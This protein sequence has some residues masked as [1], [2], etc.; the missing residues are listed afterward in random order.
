MLVAGLLLG[1]G[2][3]RADDELR[4]AK[5]I[6]VFLL[7]GQS[8]MQG[9]GRVEK[10]PA[11]LRTIP[12]VKFFAAGSG[13]PKAKGNQWMPLQS[14]NGR[15]FGVEMGFGE[16]IKTLRGDD[17]VA[18][19][20]FAAS[21][22]SLERGWKPGKNAQ[23]AGNWGAQFKGFVATVDAGIAALE[24]EGWTPVIQG[25]C[26][27]QGEQDA[28]AGLNVEESDQSALEYAANLTAFI[29]R[30]REQFA[31][32]AGESGIRFVAGQVLPYAPMGGDVDARFPGRDLVCQAVLDLASNS[33]SE[34][35]L[36]NVG[37]VATDDNTCQTHAQDGDDYNPNDEVHLN[38]RGLL[39]L[40][41][42]MAREVLGVTGS[43]NE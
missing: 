6:D 35:A 10:L 29:A 21:G 39:F 15:Q 34:I 18:L 9:T 41:R 19:I 32:H 25:M 30:V 33:G 17:P 14:A 43:Q 3:G 5:A 31:E 36:D 20:K 24:A 28:K 11:E 42:E 23:D 22:T 8:N 16:A 1:R 27:Q 7:G 38:E 40:G 26:W 4:P 13:V 12:E 37:A 2:E